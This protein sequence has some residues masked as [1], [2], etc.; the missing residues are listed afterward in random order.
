MNTDTSDF[1]DKKLKNFFLYLFILTPII[2]FF[3]KFLADLFLSLVAIYTLLDLTKNKNFFILNNFLFFF[4]FIF[5]ISLNLLINNFNLLLFA[6]SFLLIRFPLYM[7]FPLIFGFDLKSLVKKFKIFFIFPLI[8]F[9]INLYLEVFFNINIF[10]SIKGNDY[11]RVTSFFGEEY[12]AGSYLFFIFFMVFFFSKELNNLIVILLLVI[13]FAI[14]F[15]GDRTPFI[16]INL[17][18]F[19]YAIFNL[20]KIFLSKKINMIIFLILLIIGSSYTVHY[21]NIKKISAYSK[22]ENTFKDIKKD[23]LTSDKNERSLK[24]WAY[25]GIFLKSYTIF[26]KNIIFGTSYKSFRVECKK[27]IYDAEYF[28]LTGNLNF[29]GCS[30]HPHN[31][32]LEVLSEQGILGFILFILLIF[33][34][35]NLAKKNTNLNHVI[36]RFFIIT[37]FFPFKPFGSFYTNF[38]MI[39]L[40]ATIAIFLIFNNKKTIE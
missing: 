13:Y 40:S 27:K 14:F 15:S 16:S 30:T 22:Y 31:I 34:L 17:F 20:K 37:Y 3:S 26:K 32:Y 18:I 39:M 33:G 6:K 9:L 35:F 10:G 4:I 7:L 24:R 1:S 38:G 12:I 28:N 19:L 23:I 11:Q 36:F 29:N 8:I 25:Y 2:I 21:K 5:Y